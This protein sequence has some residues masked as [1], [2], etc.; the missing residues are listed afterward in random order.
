MGMDG[1][2]TPTP[3]TGRVQKSPTALENDLSEVQTA[4][5]IT[6]TVHITTMQVFVESSFSSQL[7]LLNRYLVR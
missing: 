1:D 5:I 4:H 6:H 3:Q 7:R 2:L